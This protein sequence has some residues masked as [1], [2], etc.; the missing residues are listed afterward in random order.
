MCFGAR[1]LSLNKE[2]KVFFY[3]HN[4]FSFY[5]RFFKETKIIYVKYFENYEEL[6]KLFLRSI[7]MHYIIITFFN[8]NLFSFS[9]DTVS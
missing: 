6:S 2:V 4:I 8:N 7:L 5:L 1:V 3:R 9:K